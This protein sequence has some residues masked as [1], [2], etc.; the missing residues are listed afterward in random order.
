MRI[1]TCTDHDLHYPVV[2]ASVV[3]AANEAD[4]RKLLDDA[5]VARGLL[6]FAKAEYSLVEMDT[7]SPKAVI[8]RD[9]DY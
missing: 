4:A 7:T 6:P 1:Y 3:V 8:L 9:G 5:L 2:C